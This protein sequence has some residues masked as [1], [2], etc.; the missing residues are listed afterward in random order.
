[1]YEVKLEFD[2]QWLKKNRKG[3]ISVLRNIETWLDSEKYYKTISCSTK[4][5]H[6]AVA[7]GYLDSFKEA[8]IKKIWTEYGFVHPDRAFKFIAVETDEEKPPSFW[9]AK[10]PRRK[11]KIN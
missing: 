3:E 11:P 4:D 6:V 1:M 8:L 2:E 5:M 7:T 9:T 10:E